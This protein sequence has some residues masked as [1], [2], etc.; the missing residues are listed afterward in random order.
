MESIDPGAYRSIVVLTG[1]GLSVA[2]GIKP[3]RG[4]GGLWNDG[5]LVRLSHIDTFMRDPDSVW[6][7]WGEARI[8]A[9]RAEPNSAHLALAEFERSLPEDS[10]FLLATQNVDGLHLRAGSRRVAEL[11]GRVRRTRCSDP[12]CA[13]EPFDDDESYSGGTPRC[14]LCGSPLRPDIVFFGETLGPE[15][16]E[17]AVAVASCDLFIA[18]GTSGTVWPAADYA[19]K[20]AVSGARTIF[21]NL[22]PLDPPVPWFREIRLGRAEEILPELLGVRMDARSGN[23]RQ[24]MLS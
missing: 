1:A 10:R 2:S 12:E 6:S 20:A 24:K 8:D 13:L 16:R 9:A 22:E 17:A 11:H 19:R 7:F 18:A 23:A 14:P 3:F 5:T 4:P 15:G 21:V